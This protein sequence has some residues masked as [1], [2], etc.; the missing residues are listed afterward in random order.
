MIKNEPMPFR[1]PI[2][3]A[4]VALA[5]S[6][7][8][9]RTPSHVY[10]S[11]YTE[12]KN[13]Y[14]AYKEPRLY[15]PQKGPALKPEKE[16]FYAEEVPYGLFFHEPS[17]E[18]W[19]SY[20]YFL[21][22]KSAMN[23]FPRVIPETEYEIPV[24]FNGRV[25]HFLDYF[26][27]RGRE[28]FSI[29]LSRSGKYIPMMKVILE[30]WG[31]PTDLVYMAMI[32]SGFNVKA[33]SHMGAVGPWQ[34]IYST[35]KRYGLRIDS[36]VDERMD[37]EKS[38]I[39]AANYLS[40]LYEMFQSWE[41][42]AAG[43]NCGE[44]RVQAAIDRYEVSDFWE[45]SEYTLPKETK[46]YVPKF[47]A[48]L[49]IAKNPEKYG[50]KGIEYQ[51]SEPVERVQVLSQRSLG[52]IA[53]VIG[54]SSSRLS[55]MNPSLI[56]SST[57]PGD[58]YEI[59]VPLGYREVVVAKYDEI[60]ELKV[61]TAKVRTTTYSSYRVRRGD[62]LG[63]IASRFGV[64]VSSLKRANGIR[65]SLIRTGQLLSIPGGTGRSYSRVYSSSVKYRVRPGDTLGGIAAR[66]GSSV[67]SIKAANGIRGSVIR[68]G[69]LLT[70]PR[71]G[72]SYSGGDT[73]SYRVKRG[74]T[75]WEIARRYRVSISDIKRW[76]NLRSSTLALGDRL[77]IYSR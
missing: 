28:S 1:Y 39:A 57:P 65:G 50:F 3:I 55:E 33:R 41:L 2:V 10:S 64:S 29:W 42:A 68:V 31:M 16:E 47:M 53:R 60:S 73:I 71:R 72:S 48:A 30:Q 20:Y 45:I 58:P 25:H 44:E 4:L 67:S 43:Y 75:L 26:Q 38:T 14:D 37:P 52:D 56:T 13:V 22:L 70:V 76:N 24:V 51:D 46:D 66:Y 18:T 74:D 19:K 6:G 17:L 49:I 5:F 62:T 15:R 34:F 12:N 35:G 32:E 59:N 11:P 40:D 61:V 9:T 21:H 23:E 77:T 7:C 27:G 54:V 36:W 69:Q 63:R 8:V